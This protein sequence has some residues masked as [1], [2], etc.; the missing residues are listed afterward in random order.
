MPSQ[1]REAGLLLRSLSNVRNNLL[2]GLLGT[3]D[4]S[5]GLGEVYDY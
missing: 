3:N 4:D 5:T 1:C 2:L